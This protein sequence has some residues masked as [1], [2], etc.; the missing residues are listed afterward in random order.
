[1]PKIVSPQVEFAALL[2]QVREITPKIFDADHRFLNLLDG[3]WQEPRPPP[4]VSLAHRRQPARQPAHAQPGKWPYAPVRAAKREAAAWAAHRPRRAPRQ[5]AGFPRR[6]APARGADWQAADVGIG[7]TYKL[8]FTDIDRAVDG[9]QWYV[10][11]LDELL[12]DSTP[13]GLVSNIA[14]WSYPMSVPAARAVSFRLD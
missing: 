6:P 12:G 5:S 1:M 2:A 4:E 7:K 10:D 3:R 13:L 9:A 11:N 8:G 14:S